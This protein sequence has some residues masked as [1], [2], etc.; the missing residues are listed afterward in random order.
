MTLQ[1]VVC[2]ANIDRIEH[3]FVGDI[4]CRGDWNAN[5][6][7]PRY[8]GYDKDFIP[9]S[10]TYGDT[11]ISRWISMGTGVFGWNYF[12]T[13]GNILG[14]FGWADLLFGLPDQPIP[15]WLAQTSQQGSLATGHRGYVSVLYKDIG[16]GL[17]GKEPPSLASHSYLINRCDTRAD[18]RVQWEDTKAQTGWGLNAVHIIRELIESPIIGGGLAEERID[19]GTFYQECV[20]LFDEGMGLGFEISSTQVEAWNIVNRILDIIEGYIYQDYT[21]GKIKIK[22]LRNDYDYDDLDELDEDDYEVLDGFQK[23]NNTTNYNAVSV[24]YTDKYYYKKKTAYYQDDDAV[25]K[26]GKNPITL[27]YAWLWNK[28]LA[29][30]IA[31]NKVIQSTA[32]LTVCR[33][34]GGLKLNKYNLGDP[35]RLSNKRLGISGV[36]YRVV[37]K[38]IGSFEEGT[39]KLGFVE[40]YFG[41]GKGGFGTGGTEPS[42]TEVAPVTNPYVCEAPYFVLKYA[43][44]GNPDTVIPLDKTRAITSAGTNT[45]LIDYTNYWKVGLLTEYQEDKDG[46]FCCRRTLRNDLFIGMSY[47]T[48]YVDGGFIPQGQ[49]LVCVI[50]DEI[51]YVN[52]YYEDVAIIYRGQQDTLPAYHEAGSQICFLN[53][54]GNF[55]ILDENYN[56]DILYNFKLVAN[57]LTGRQAIDEAVELSMTGVKRHYL[58]YN[59]ARLQVNSAFSFQG[60]PYVTVEFNIGVNDDTTVTWAPRNRIYT[61]DFW[62]TQMSDWSGDMEDS[63]VVRIE[64]YTMDAGYENTLLRVADG[65]TAEGVIYTRQLERKDNP[66]GQQVV[67]RKKIILW[68]KRLKDGSTTEYWESFQKW[69]FYV[70]R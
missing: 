24:L 45:N 64:F 67:N 58:P 30:N 70:N 40:D 2:M 46:S 49:T 69:V 21:T 61:W 4:P 53:L 7:T 48:I 66:A 22:L 3:I 47:D 33:I 41:R 63:T 38:T 31:F 54:D 20:K 11:F 28:E 59:V 23:K 43:W 51:C 17:G 13:A 5:L 8:F 29:S 35:V 34:K 14:H 44:G 19:N 39:I 57:S 62:L 50:D 68:T 6:T 37:S 42:P 52:S 56:L 36:V 25:A 32:E 15:E 65:I 18:G 27:D 55:N 10:E 26:Y 16:I 9:R 1:D 12:Q 60:D